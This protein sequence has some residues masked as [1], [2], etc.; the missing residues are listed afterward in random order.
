MDLEEAVEAKESINCDNC[1]KRTGHGS[2]GNHWICAD[3]KICPDEMA[4]GFIQYV[5]NIPSSLE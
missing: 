3:C 2:V 5:E 1:L 4:D